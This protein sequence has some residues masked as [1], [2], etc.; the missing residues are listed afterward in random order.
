VVEIPAD[1]ERE[2]VIEEFPLPGKEVLGNKLD[3]ILNAVPEEFKI[4]LDG[5]K[6]NRVLDAVLGMTANE[7]E[8][9][10]ARSIIECEDL[11]VKMLTEHKAQ[12]IKKTG[13]LEW[14]RED[15]D[16]DGG[17]GGLDVLKNWIRKR[18]KAFSEK[19]REF[20]LPMP[21]GVVVAGTPGGG[22]SMSAK[23]TAHDW[24]IP[25]LRLDMG[26]I[27]GSLVGQSEE[28][29]KKALAI[30]E[31]IAPC[32]LWIDEVEKAL[33]GVGG[34]GNLDSGTG[35][36]VFGF[37]LTWLQEHTAPVFVFAT[38]NDIKSL[39]PEFLRKG[40]RFDE[41]FFIGLPNTKER[42]AI[43]KIHL[44]MVK[45]YREEDFDINK[46]ANLT[47]EFSGAEIKSIID[48]SLFDAFDEESSLQMEHL[49]GTIEGTIPL[50][51][52]MEKELSELREWGKTHAKMAST[53]DKKK[54]VRLVRGE[55]AIRP[56]RQ[57]KMRKSP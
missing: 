8:N 18:R 50:S 12:V 17:V 11:D 37:F 36:R 9:A 16:M 3:V 56:K 20:G 27:F 13:A 51:K 47:K 38:A 34:S 55:R 41:I 32:V 29:L 10:F 48:S 53:P 44:S 15:I 23:A 5:E 45:D 26:S 46:L 4:D 35:K 6:R 30:A 43:W 22:K 7:A 1:I 28:N 40:G 19:A 39:P 42:E 24:S 49:V 57:S 25:L 14:V 33:A 52:T 2:I 31:R 21:R 54:D